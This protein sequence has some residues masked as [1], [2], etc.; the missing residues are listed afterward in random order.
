MEYIANNVLRHT[1]KYFSNDALETLNVPLV[2][3]SITVLKALGDSDSAKHKKLP[4]ES[5]IQERNSSDNFRNHQC[6]VTTKRNSGKNRPIS[7]MGKA[8]SPVRSSTLSA[9]HSTES[10]GP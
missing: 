5:K 4:A 7:H 2:S 9:A 10:T 3:M 1:L 6:I 8:T